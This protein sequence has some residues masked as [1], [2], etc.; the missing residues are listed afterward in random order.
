MEDSGSFLRTT[1]NNKEFLEATAVATLKAV[2]HSM[3]TEVG[4]V[5]SGFGEVDVQ[6]LE[7]FAD[8]HPHCPQLAPDNVTRHL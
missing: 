2:I 8:V 5:V 7:P 6:L 1:S 3:V 4:I